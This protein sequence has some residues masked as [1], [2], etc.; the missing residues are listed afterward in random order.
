MHEDDLRAFEP[1][2]M[3]EIG[4]GVAYNANFCRN[5][6]CPNF[7]PAPDIEAYRARYTVKAV[8]DRPRDREYECNVCKMH[9]PLMS[10]RSLRA[11]YAWFKR[12]SIPFAACS[13]P[14]CVNDGV[15]VFEYCRRYRKDSTAKPHLARCR[16]EGRPAISLGETINLNG[17]DAEV[18]GRLDEVFRTL[19]DRGGLRDRV[20]NLLAY[21]DYTIG[22]S[23]YLRTLK[24]IAPRLRDYHS[25]CNTGLMA[26]DYPARLDRL[27]KEEKGEEKPDAPKG[28]PYNGVATLR[29]DLMRISLGKRK[30]SNRA[31]EEDRDLDR[32]HPLDVL[33]TAL[34]I[35]RSHVESEK[36]SSTPFL[37]AAHP[38]VVLKRGGQSPAGDDV[39]SM[40]DDAAL[41]VADRQYDH[42]FHSGTDHGK[43]AHVE[44]KQSHLSAGGLF[45][46]SDYAEHAHF[47]VLKE[48]T[49]CFRRV[50]L[51]MDGA[52]KAY[53]HA[54][55]VFAK[56]LRTVCDDSGM[57]CRRV[58]IAV[59]Q[60]EKRSRKKGGVSPEQ[61]DAICDAE[62]RRVAREW[63]ERLAAW[64]EEKGTADLGDEDRRLLTAEAK[65]ELFKQVTR[66]GWQ[67]DATWGWLKRPTQRGNRILA[68]L[69]LSQGPERD[70]PPNRIVDEFLRRTSLQ[71]VDIAMKGLRDTFSSGRR[72]E[73]RAGGGI[74]YY[75]SSR[76]AEVAACQIWLY[77][78]FLNYLRLQVEPGKQRASLLGLLR[79]EGR[80]G[81]DIARLLKFRLT[82]DHAVE[83][84]E[85]LGNVQE[86]FP[87]RRPARAV[88]PAKGASGPGGRQGKRASGVRAA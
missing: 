74:T 68:T 28:S 77:S 62:N 85:N 82:W 84:T 56:D 41:P 9:W 60:A 73:S 14:G 49:A 38:F 2:L 55:G 47:M 86:T 40:H 1:V 81:F 22:R 42:L 21:R 23:R 29:T 57:E 79:R 46:R 30:K 44:G 13:R 80:K 59:L 76:S 52:V 31:R 51:C 39:G 78:F 11:A 63:T 32:H 20:R 43:D 34:R 50:T 65:V 4:L 37:L 71:S 54:A 75:R 53:G 17:T 45:M 48:L 88:L 87:R 69:W 33:M 6:M 10:N 72:A 3:Q 15:N 8:E 24:Q 5:P 58:E 12:Q 83:I 18:A 7:G 16:C 25:Y 64:L 36:R 61:Q 70:G 35:D 67:A 66:G 19:R 27:F 26:P